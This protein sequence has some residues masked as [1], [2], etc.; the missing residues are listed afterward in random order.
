MG[1]LFQFSCEFSSLNGTYYFAHLHGFWGKC[2]NTILKQCSC[3]IFSV[4]ST[5]NFVRSDCGGRQGKGQT[6]PEKWGNPGFTQTQ[7]LTASEMVRFFP[8]P[9]AAPCLSL[10]ELGGSL[11]FRLTD[12]VIIQDQF[13]WQT[14]MWVSCLWLADDWRGG[15]SSSHTTEIPPRSEASKY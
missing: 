8:G 10:L 15:G 11:L 5:A 3:L 1:S 9:H 2:W 7:G 6:P 14:W 13:P 12:W 4:N